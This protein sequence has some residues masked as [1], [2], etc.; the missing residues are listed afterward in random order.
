MSLKQGNLTGPKL[1]RSDPVDWAFYATSKVTPISFSPLSSFGRSFIDKD[2]KGAP[3]SLKDALW[4]VATNAIG[5]PK[6]YKEEQI[7]VTK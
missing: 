4:K 3:D 2:Y 1:D 5:F 6:Y 7:D